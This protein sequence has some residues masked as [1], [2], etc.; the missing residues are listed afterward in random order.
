MR[1]LTPFCD[2]QRFSTLLKLT[3]LHS[4]KFPAFRLPVYEILRVFMPVSAQDVYARL[5]LPHRHG[6]PLWLP[7]PNQSLPPLV[8]EQGIQ[9]GDVGLINDYGDFTTLF[10]IFFPK[11]HSVNMVHGVPESFQPLEF[12]QSQLFTTDYH[13]GK[14][15]IYSKHTK[16]V[17]FGADGTVMTPCVS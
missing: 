13:K 12:R 16:E 11:D 2:V 15:P 10:N 3:A 5:L 17:R 4:F 1:K 7:E 14:V 6:Y 8:Y 9:L